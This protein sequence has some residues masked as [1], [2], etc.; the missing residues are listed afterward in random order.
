MLHGFTI[1]GEKKQGFNVQRH[2]EGFSFVVFAEN[3][4]GDVGAIELSLNENQLAGITTW[5]MS[6]IAQE[7]S[8]ET[9]RTAVAWLADM[10]ANGYLFTEA[11]DEKMKVDEKL[12]E[13]LEEIRV[14]VRGGDGR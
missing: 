5:L 3:E 10:R 8:P 11:M 1:P 7:A 6:V 4:N 9:M 13:K 12:N 14:N 2:E